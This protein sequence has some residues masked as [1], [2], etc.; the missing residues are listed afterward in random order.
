MTPLVSKVRGDVSPKKSL[1]CVATKSNIS[2]DFE[3]SEQIFPET[4]RWVPLLEY[5][6]WHFELILHV[7]VFIFELYF[8]LDSFFVCRKNWVKWLHVQYWAILHASSLRYFLFNWRTAQYCSHFTQF[9]LQ[10]INHGK[11][12]KQFSSGRF[13]FQAVFYVFLP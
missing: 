11:C 10:T 8:N 12:C 7:I 2:G 13:E 4:N 5:L 9:F 1:S 3:P 6:P